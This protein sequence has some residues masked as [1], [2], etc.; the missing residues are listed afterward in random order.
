MTKL[1]EKERTVVHYVLEWAKRMGEANGRVVVDVSGMKY[2]WGQALCREQ[3]GP[4]WINYMR[5]QNIIVPDEDDLE[6]AL[7]W[8]QG[9]KPDWVS[10]YRND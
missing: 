5:T 4:D 3:F 2:D 10:E 8:E 1:S 6:R 9:V 7:E